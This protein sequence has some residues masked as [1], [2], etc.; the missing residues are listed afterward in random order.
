MMKTMLPRFSFFLLLTAASILA[1]CSSSSV[2]ASIGNEK[3]S[4]EEFEETYAKNNGGWDASAKSSLE[5]RQ[6]FLDLIIKF[7]LKVQEAKGQGLLQDTSIQN[8]LDTYRLSVAQTY[9]LEKEL[10]EP[11]LK[12]MYQRKL[13]ELRASHILFRLAPNAPPADTAAAYNRALS[14]IKMIPTESFDSLAV[15]FSEDPSAAYNK[16]DLGFFTVSRMVPEF[17]DACFSLKAGQ[18]TTLPVRTQFGYHVLKLTARQPNPGSARINHILKRF[19]PD[20]KDSLVVRDTMRAIY[21]RLK[22]GYPFDQAAT[23]SSE[24]PGSAARGG[25]IGVFE[26]AQL[27]PEMGTLL[28]SAPVDS[29]LEPFRTVYGYHIFKVTERKNIPAFAEL[30]RD[31]RQQYQQ[32]RY[33]KDYQQYL[34]KLKRQYQLSIDTPQVT[35]L[36]QNIKIARS[37]SDSDWVARV[38]KEFLKQRLIAVSARSVS[39]NDFLEKAQPFADSRKIPAS[40][41]SLLV[42]V[43]RIGENLVI[44]EHASAAINRHP[45][46]G[47]LMQEYLEGILLY[48]IEQ[49]EIWKKLAVNDSVLRPFYNVNKEKYRWPDRVNFAEIF[50]TSDSVAK[51]AYWKLQFG[52][53]FLSVAEEH[54]MRTG[55]REKLGVWGFQ[56][57]TLNE[58]T[59]RASKMIIDSVSPIFRHE[60]GWSIIKVIG[61]DIARVKTF[62]EAG[63]ELVSGYQEQAAK[64]RELEWMESLKKKYPV[65]VNRDA[66]G[67]AFKVKRLEAQ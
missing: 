36:G 17:E 46:F 34:L 64:T 33:E 6:R 65:T 29:V 40:A 26:R 37:L 54:T 32:M 43:D 61:R 59:A 51:R 55:Y 18:Y 35:R 56:P 15:T 22:Q 21:R 30:E 19:S 25:E 42:I 14:I 63:P 39:V 41:D 10:V 9:M 20:G 38:P 47:R 60:N 62:E 23:A 28:F 11:H 12:D 13:E 31:L 1:G 44:E 53:D 50:V 49:D 2:V 66:V 58:L 16:G 45:A 7:K 5:D 57:L 52:E 8:E 4:L 3:L 48:R 67:K 24:D 27:P